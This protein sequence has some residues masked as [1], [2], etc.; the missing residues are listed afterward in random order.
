VQYLNLAEKSITYWK[1]CMYKIT[2]VKK[3][4]P[5]SGGIIDLI[6]SWLTD[7]VGSSKLVLLQVRSCQYMQLTIIK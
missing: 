2:K 3:F 4:M 6:E 5:N 1:D 7:R